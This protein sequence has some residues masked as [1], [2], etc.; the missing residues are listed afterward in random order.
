MDILKTVIIASVYVVGAQIGYAIVNGFF[1]RRRSEREASMK[2]I[3]PT[4]EK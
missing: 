4:K 1:A 2:N 3:T